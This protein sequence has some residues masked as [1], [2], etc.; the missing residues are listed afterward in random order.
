MMGFK[1]VL[2]FASGL[3][4]VYEVDTHRHCL[5]TMKMGCKYIKVAFPLGVAL[6]TLFK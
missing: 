2:P 1:G 3:G 5:H 6:C 4:A